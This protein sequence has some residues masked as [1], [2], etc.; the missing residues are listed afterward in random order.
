MNL[1]NIKEYVKEEKARLKDRI[2][3]KT[4]SLAIIQVGE[5]EAS[6][7][8]VKNKIKDCEEIG[9]FPVLYKAPV[10]IT[11]EILEEFITKA[12][13]AYS[14]III[15][16]PLP[17]HLDKEKLLKLIP[18]EKDV[19]GFRVD[20]LFKPC[21]PKGIMDYLAACGLSD[22]SGKNVTIIG[23]S[24]IVGKPLALMMLEANATVTICHS[25]TENLWQHLKNADVIVSAVGRKNFLDCSCIDDDTI[26]IDVGININ[27]EGKLVGDCCNIDGK[28][29]T[30]VPGGVGLLTRLALMKNTI[31]AAEMQ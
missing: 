9:I 23:R 1:K 29:V 10:D 31:D 4:A 6:N 11:Q 19:D 26:V 5:V 8:Y 17:D 30:P 20:S 22:F 7:R 12:A 3:A 18:V 15:Q 27:D 28:N 14:G 16:L 21:T 25:R 13:N 24:D 2:N